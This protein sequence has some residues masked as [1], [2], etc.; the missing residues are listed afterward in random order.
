MNGKL[1]YRKRKEQISTGEEE[2]KDGDMQ[3]EPMA[4]LPCK[5]DEDF[6]RFVVDF[7]DYKEHTF[8]EIS[9]LK[10]E[11]E[12][13][14]SDGNCREKMDP[15]KMDQINEALVRS[16]HERILSLERQLAYQHEIIS[17]LLDRPKQ[18]M[19]TSQTGIPPGKLINAPP[20]GIKNETATKLS[21]DSSTNNKNDTREQKSLIVYEDIAMETSQ[22][23]STKKGK[24]KKLKSKNKTQQQLEA[25]TNVNNNE[26]DD[27]PVESKEKKVPNVIVN[28]VMTNQY[29]II[30]GDS[31]VKNLQG[32]RMKTSM[33][34]NEKVIVRSFPAASTDGM[35]F[36]AVP[37][38]KKKPRCFVL[39]TG[40]ND[41][42]NEEEDDEI[43]KTI[44][45]L[46]KTLKADENTV[47][48]SGIINRDDGKMNARI[49]NVNRVLK[50]LC[51]E[52]NFPFIDN[53]NI[54]VS[55][56]LNRSGLHFF[57]H[58]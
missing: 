27:K 19:S 32:W 48:V 13:S 1:S 24:K 30:L 57:H 43:A 17:K 22:M 49:T 26:R 53:S 12:K 9:S 39:H 33:K 20:S 44:F 45:G 50:E 18:D 2:F 41:F 16:L 29:V 47:Y 52:A 38:M 5:K 54:E 42:R 10:A 55:H 8:K 56:H 35:S 31:M 14:Q 23:D 4:E 11:F 34:S 25:N 6:E 51:G 40:A 36:H 7:Q 3:T 58:Y 37:F 15:Q 46:A 21:N 28:K